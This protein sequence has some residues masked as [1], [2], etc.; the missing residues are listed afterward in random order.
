MQSTLSASLYPHYTLLTIVLFF[1]FL[2]NSEAPSL[3]HCSY[4]SPLHLSFELILMLTGLVAR[5]GFCLFLGDLL[6]S[7]RSKKQDVVSC[8][9]C[10]AEFRAMATTTREIVHVRRL[11]ADFGIFLMCYKDCH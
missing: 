7:W 6:I 5:I 10:E 1:E 3:Y 2:D 4:P 9:S 11:L 8:S